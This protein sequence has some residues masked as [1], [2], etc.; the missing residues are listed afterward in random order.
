MHRKNV[1]RR[2]IHFPRKNTHNG[3]VAREVKP[4]QNV[5]KIQNFPNVNQLYQL[6]YDLT[7]AFFFRPIYRLI[8]LKIQNKEIVL[9]KYTDN[10]SIPGKYSI[11]K[12]FDSKYNNTTNKIFQC[13]ADQK[14]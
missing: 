5:P 9:E 12:H 4:D 14:Y 2:T 13:V 6:C 10:G 3:Y 7:N 11:R 1:C 8:K